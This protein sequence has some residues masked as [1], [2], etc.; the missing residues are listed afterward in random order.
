MP[1]VLAAGFSVADLAP[2]I[3]II[4][5]IVTVAG[6][7]VAYLIRRRGTTGTTD[8]SEA[9]TLWQQ[10]QAMFTQITAERDKAIEQRD[11]L[12]EAQSGQVVP[13]LSATLAVTQQLMTAFEQQGPMFTEM[14]GLMRKI[15]Q[16]EGEEM[17]P[18]MEEMTK[19]IAMM[20]ARGL[21]MDRT[22]YLVEA[23]AR[24]YGVTGNENR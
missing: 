2:Y 10:S 1:P 16:Q 11:K 18:V 22:A 15:S 12:M 17:V 20:E 21:L 5:F 24:R 6:G 4:L 8:T 9:G 13:I 23:L 3:G 14:H 19:I 7:I